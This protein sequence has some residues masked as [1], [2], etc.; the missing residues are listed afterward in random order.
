MIDSHCHINDPLYSSNPEQYVLEAKEAGV[1]T[2]LV[3]GY[4]L[5]S[6]KKAIEIASRFD[7]VYAAVGI[8]P[9]DTKKMGP[10][11]LKEI[12]S[13]L[14]NKK[15][16]AIGEIGLDYH[17]DNDPIIK[18]KQ[19]EYFKYQIG[20]AN[21]Y[22]L[23]ISIHSRDADE[24]TLNCLIECPPLYGGVMHCYSG[25]KEM[26]PRFLKL[27]LLIGIGGVVTFKNAVKTKEVA[28]NVPSDSYLLETDAPYLAPTPYRG[29][30]NHSKYIPLIIEEI[31]KLRNEPITKVIEDTTNNFK[32]LFKI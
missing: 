10:N 31:A 17:W 18:E 26:M 3:I 14:I 11:D 12:E 25:S 20:L 9:T 7:G 28:I 29:K 1:N 30:E 23:P 2:M 6:S 8:H 15:V 5:E 4:D 27:G 22:K 16:I 32:R 24:A 13:L 19:K 21:K